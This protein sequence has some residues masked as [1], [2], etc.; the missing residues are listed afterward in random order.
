MDIITLTYLP[1]ISDVVQGFNKL[2]TCVWWIARRKFFALETLKWVRKAL[3]KILFRE[4]RNQWKRP[5]VK[6]YYCLYM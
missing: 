5:K 2:N 1:Q 6:M 4:C 3:H